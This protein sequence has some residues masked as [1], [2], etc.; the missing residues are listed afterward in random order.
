[1]NAY[2]FD[3]TIYD[4]DCTID[5]YLFCLKKHKHIIFLLPIQIWGMLIYKLKIKEKE[6]FKEKF[7]V[8]LLKI[9][10]ID[11]TIQQFSKKNNYKI[12]DWYI[13][14]K[15]DNDVIISASP[16]FLVNELLKPLNIKYVIASDVDKKTGKFLSKNCYGEEKVKRFEE[17]FPNKKIDS[18]YSDSMSDLPMMKLAEKSYLVKDNKIEK[19][20][21]E[22]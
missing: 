4:G 15:N 17:V 6:Y 2:D 16:Y 13:K 21:V 1:M 10:D 8:F 7:F 22:K 11:K 9:K 14:Q 20:K 19:I 3:K 5:F 18:F 12:K